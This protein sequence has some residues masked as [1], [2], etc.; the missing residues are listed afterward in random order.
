M[1]FHVFIYNCR[2]RQ[3]QD[4]VPTVSMESSMMYVGGDVTPRSIPSHYEQL[5]STRYGRTQGTPRSVASDSSS[6]GTSEELKDALNL[7]ATLNTT[8]RLQTGS[9]V[10]KRHRDLFY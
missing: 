10:T 5:G 7:R 9:F 3:A 4:N 1:T 2:I 8:P 6:S